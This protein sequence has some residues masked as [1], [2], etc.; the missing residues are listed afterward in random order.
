[1]MLTLQVNEKMNIAIGANPSE[2]EML[3]AKF[4]RIELQHAPPGGLAY[5]TVQLGSI[6]L[7]VTEVGR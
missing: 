4:T 3:K 6:M 2:F 1:M 5:F 7:I